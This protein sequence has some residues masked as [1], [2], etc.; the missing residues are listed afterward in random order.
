VPTL[1][2]GMMFGR[3]RIGRMLGE[4][5]MGQVFEAYDVELARTV[6]LKILR[7]SSLK[8]ESEAA[9]RVRREA[10]ASSALNHP[11]AAAI[12]DVGELEGTSFIAMELVSGVSLRTYVE[13]HQASLERRLRWLAQI[14]DVLAAAHDRGIVHRDLKPDNIMVNDDDEVK[15]L[16]FGVAKRLPSADIDPLAQTLED[17]APPSSGNITGT[18]RYMSPEQIRGEPIDARSDQF[19]W[20]IVAY[21]LVCGRHPW[22]TLAPGANLYRAITAEMPKPLREVVPTA[23]LE[24]QALVMKTLAKDPANR[25]PSMREVIA[26]LE[27]IVVDEVESAP[28]R[29]SA[30]AREDATVRE[31]A[32]R[33][34]RRAP[35]LIAAVAISIAAGFATVRGL[36]RDPKPAGP[37]PVAS[38]VRK[39]WMDLSKPSATSPAALAAYTAGLQALEDG[40]IVRARANFMRAAT[41][42]PTL[43]A[44]LLRAALS[45][46]PFVA[47]ESRDLLSEA[48]KA[49]REASENRARLDTRDRELLEAFE[50]WLL[51]SPPSR[52]ELVKRLGELAVR[53]PDDVEIA[54][55]LAVAHGFGDPEKAAA[56]YDIALAMDDRFAGA[57]AAKAWQQALL[58]D[59]AGAKGSIDR[60]LSISPGAITCWY[61]RVRL[62]QAEGRCADLESDARRWLEIDGANEL[63]YGY[64]AEGEFAL[65][66]QSAA[67]RQSVEQRLAMAGDASTTRVYWDQEL[68][69]LDGDFVT[70]ERLA[71]DDQRRAAPSRD[72]IVHAVPAFTLVRLYF[73]M[74]RDQEAARVAADY[75]SRKDAWLVTALVDDEAIAADFVPHMIAAE[76]RGGLLTDDQAASQ[77]DAWLRD[78]EGRTTPFFSRYLW[79]FGRAP[80]VWS[81]A[82]ADDAMAHAPPADRIAVFGSKSI[83]SDAHVGRTLALAGR[84][85][86]ALPVLR[87]ATHS[88]ATLHWGMLETQTFAVLGSVLE[89]KGDTR[90]ACDA[91]R[92][93]ISRW[94]HAKPR[95]VT[96]ESATIRAKALR[97]EP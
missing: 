81:K 92:T 52:A 25:F 83:V 94:G 14:A 19:A 68:A 96:A 15:V 78:W 80:G 5:G 55:Y 39:S 74:G 45:D 48:R 87:R 75:M 27:S 44:A 71:L 59:L 95:S 36:K 46:L 23:P 2:K 40:S 6:A 34:R 13:D 17:Q 7:P 76:R 91:Y 70:A 30:P 66:K 11:N 37:A 41:L 82:D 61:E 85:D 8:G 97:C 9:A 62:A 43:A 24:L 67:V 20:G 56:A 22:A 31:A 28:V 26:M 86:D 18:P 53:H 38:T 12:F 1:T 51:D 89:Q 29:T 88:C 93:V 16:D 32:P 57:L 4:G 69:Q 54:F 10:R 3:Y 77:R 58:G 21:E 65:G 60:C 50:P 73:E 49:F 72:R 33:P 47:R 90:G 35:W 79:G 63:A 84:W 64:L 42:E